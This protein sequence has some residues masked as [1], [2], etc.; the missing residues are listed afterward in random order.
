VIG[1]TLAV[2]CFKRFMSS[3][4]ILLAAF[5]VLPLTVAIPGTVKADTLPTVYV[6]GSVAFWEGNIG[7]PPYGG[8]LNGQSESFYCVDFSHNIQAGDSWQVNVT[9]LAGS[10]FGS[11]RLSNQQYGG[12]SAYLVMAYL[13]TEMMG[14]G[15]T[16]QNKAAYQYAI[17]SF[18]GGPANPYG[19][20]SVILAS[21]LTQMTNSHFNGQGWAVLTP[22]GSTGQEFLIYVP[23][24]AELLMLLIGLAVLALAT[25][26]KHTSQPQIG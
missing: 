5:A 17:W 18:S 14:P 7:I 11:T 20:N 13:I 10:N 2:S 15:V 4:S 26:K 3:K 23:E 24:P 22:T 21:A 8:T 9:N 16:N 25:R 1:E 12:V 6:D 19:N